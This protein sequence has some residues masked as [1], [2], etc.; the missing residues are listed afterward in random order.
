MRPLMASAAARF[1]AVVVFPHGRRMQAGESFE[2]EAG[3]LNRKQD[4]RRGHQGIDR[5]Q[6][7]TRRTVD[8]DERSHFQLVDLVLNRKCASSSPLISPRVWRG[9]SSRGDEQVLKRR[10]RLDDSSELARRIGDRVVHAAIDRAVVQ[11]R[12]TAVGLGRDR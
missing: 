1:T 4:V 7:E 2:R 11:E 6:P 8:D 3:R 9:R 10:G 5:Q 12:D